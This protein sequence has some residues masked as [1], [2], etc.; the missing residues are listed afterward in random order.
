VKWLL[1]IKDWDFNWQNMYRYVE[2]VLLPKN[3]NPDV[4]D[5]YDNSAENARNPKSPRER[6]RWGPKS[7]DEMAISGYS[8]PT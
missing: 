5:T 7:S 8:P 1:Y 6:A 2:P 3:T 4:P